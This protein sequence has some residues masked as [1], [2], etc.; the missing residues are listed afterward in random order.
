MS[1]IFSEV[2]K[3][4]KHMTF[5]PM[6]ALL[7]T[8]TISNIGTVVGDGVQL[9]R[10]RGSV[11]RLHIIAN[12]DS[13]EDQRLKLC[14]RDELLRRGDELFECSD[15]LEDAEAC[16][17]GKLPEIKEIAEN[18]LRENGCNDKVDAEIVD[19][20]FDERTYG[21]ITMPAGNY[22]ALRITIGEAK[23]HN[24][25]CVMYP[26]LCIPAVCGVRDDASVERRYFSPRERDILHK[27]KKYRIRFAV[28]DK[29]RSLF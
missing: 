24:W 11:L 25:W 1:I 29:I 17:S 15:D 2:K 28:W 4:K 27:P 14:V 20:M 7:L 6:L 5:I 22:R 3:M 9:D 23:G 18:V 13:D 10:L 26:P 21:D 8:I 12:S 16:A 19:M